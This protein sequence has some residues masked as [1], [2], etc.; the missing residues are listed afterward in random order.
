MIL[1]NLLNTILVI[2]NYE[3]L[4]DIEPVDRELSPNIKEGKGIRLDY[5]GRTESG[6]MVNL[7]LQHDDKGY[8][9][10]RALYNASTIMHRQLLSGDDYAKICQ[11]IFIGLLG[12]SLFGRDKRTTP[13]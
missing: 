10:K 3:Q 6:R 9:E 7:E 12:F 13:Q 11:T 1:L 5:H 8:F 2:M 4:S